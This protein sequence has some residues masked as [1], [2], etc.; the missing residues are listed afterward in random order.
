MALHKVK[1]KH[2]DGTSATFLNNADSMMPCVTCLTPVTHILNPCRTPNHGMTASA[3]ATSRT[4]TT[5]FRL[6][7]FLSTGCLTS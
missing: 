2:L 7:P 1:I 5:F 3:Q 6:T 4:T